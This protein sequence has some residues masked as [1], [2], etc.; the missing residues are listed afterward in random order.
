M[1]QQQKLDL[2]QLLYL[3]KRN[4][5]KQKSQKLLTRD[6]LPQKCLYFNRIDN[7][8]KKALVIKK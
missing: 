2:S 8:I 5:Q 6:I 7:C 1:Q 4:I 3:S